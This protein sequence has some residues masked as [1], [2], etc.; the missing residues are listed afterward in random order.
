MLQ[1]RWL[2]DREERHELTWRWYFARYAAMRPDFCAAELPRSEQGKYAYVRGVN[3]Y[4]TFEWMQLEK[5]TCGGRHWNPFLRTVC[6]RAWEEGAAEPVWDE[7]A[8]PCRLLLPGGLCLT[9]NECA[10]ILSPADDGKKTSAE[11]GRAILERLCACIPSSTRKGIF[12]CPARIPRKA[13][14]IAAFRDISPE[15]TTPRTG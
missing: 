2:N 6:V 10:W 15:G 12:P 1:K 7:T 5:K 14:T 9:M 13:W 11:D 3:P 4:K 8:S